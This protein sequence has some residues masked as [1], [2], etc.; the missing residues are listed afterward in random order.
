[1]TSDVH[2]Y[3]LMKIRLLNASHSAMGYLGYLAGFRYIHEIMADS[4]FERYIRR[5]MDEEVTPLLAPVPGVDLAE[6][7]R[8]LITRFANPT[9]Q[10]QVTR[11]CLDGSSKMPKFVLPSIQEELERGGPIR[12]LSLAVAG[13]FRYLA[14]IDEQGNPIAIDDPQAQRLQKQAQAGGTDP[15]ALLSLHDLFGGLAQAPAFV[16]EVSDALRRL[17]AD[18]ARATLAHY[19][20]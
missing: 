17:Y 16:E 1:M 3:E 2:P 10:D 8:T 7:K 13:W 20:A 5:L 12:K 15:R 4:A 19:L 6:Y 18:G 11:I 9:I 14:G